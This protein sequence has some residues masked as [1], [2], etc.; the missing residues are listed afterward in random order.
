MTHQDLSERNYTI[1]A[2][3]GTGE[4]FINEN[5]KPKLKSVNPEGID[6]A[7][8]N[9]CYDRNVSCILNSVYCNQVLKFLRLNKQPT[10]RRTNLIAKHLVITKILRNNSPY[11]HRYSD[12]LWRLIE[13]GW[14]LQLHSKILVHA[15]KFVQKELTR[16]ELEIDNSSEDLETDKSFVDS[17]RLLVIM[18]IGD[19]AAI[20]FFLIEYCTR[21]DK[22]TNSLQ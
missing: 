7:L 4:I 22:L 2:F 16:R 5:L 21:E 19:F 18:C 12:I 9:M 13:Y 3:D 15:E 6:Q 1:Y 14:V 20:I 8:G 10:I 11:Y 17:A